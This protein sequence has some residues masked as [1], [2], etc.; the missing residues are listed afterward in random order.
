VA[1]EI[2]IYHLCVVQV[3]S[4][5]RKRVENEQTVLNLGMFLKDVAAIGDGLVK[6]MYLSPARRKDM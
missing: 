2:L 1:S 3:K 6:Y 5:K 4:A